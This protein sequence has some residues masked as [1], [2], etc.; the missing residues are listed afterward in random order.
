[1]SIKACNVPYATKY[2]YAASVRL[3]TNGICFKVRFRVIVSD[4]R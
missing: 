3:D 4:G 2:G 1:M